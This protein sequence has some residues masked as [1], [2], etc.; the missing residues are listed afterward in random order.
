MNGGAAAT[1][2]FLQALGGL[3]GRRGE[4]DLQIALLA[5][6]VDDRDGVAL[7][8]TG[9]TRDQ[10]DV[11]I[12]GRAHCVELLLVQRRRAAPNQSIEFLD[13]VEMRVGCFGLTEQRGQLPLHADD[14][15]Q[16]DHETPAVGI[17]GKRLFFDERVEGAL[18]TN[19]AIQGIHDQQ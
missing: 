3:T 1:A 10:A 4:H 2:D 9:S 11:V 6:G 13:G 14:L 7:A 19:P 16:S 5:D 17:A 15:G 8:R 18:D 12:E